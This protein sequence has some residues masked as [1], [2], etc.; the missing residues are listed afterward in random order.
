MIASAQEY[1][2]VSFGAGI[3]VDG[4]IMPKR[5]DKSILRGVDAGFL[6]EAYEERRVAAGSTRASPVELNGA[7]RTSWLRDVAA[8]YENLLSRPVSYGC[9]RFVRP[10]QLSARLATSDSPISDYGMD[11]PVSSLTSNTAAFSYGSRLSKDAVLALFT[12]A[13]AL[14]T[15]LLGSS[16]YTT[17]WK[18]WTMAVQGD[19]SAFSSFPPGDLYCWRSIWRRNGT[20]A[21]GSMNVAGGSL[22]YKVPA[23]DLVDR[24]TILLLAS[25][26]RSPADHQNAQTRSCW[27]P[28]EASRS[29]DAYTVGA[30]DLNSAAMT[31]MQVTGLYRPS[32]PTSIGS[33][34][35]N[36][37]AR[38]AYAVCTLTDHTNQES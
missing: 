18:N 2:F 12:D 25:V 29:G 19:A 28:L 8:Y 13:Q 21:T 3:E 5:A 11:F 31:A 7:I 16:V 10:V 37:S 36:V 27:I 22:T 23:S 1:M 26:E 24:C 9:G 30:I 34:Y 20:V 33:S 6:R 35:L 32:P 14:R 4:E 38:A 15:F 17:E